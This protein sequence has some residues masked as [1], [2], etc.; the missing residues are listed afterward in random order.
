MGDSRISAEDAPAFWGFALNEDPPPE[1]PTTP[2]GWLTLLDAAADGLDTTVTLGG[3]AKLDG[4]D[5]IRLLDRLRSITHRLGQ[6]DANLVKH[7]YVTGEHGEQ[8]LDGI[9]KVS[10]HRS[11]DRTKWDERG[12]AQAVIDKQMEKRGGEMPSE[13][14]EVISWVLE[15]FGISYCRVTPLRAMGLDPEAFC[16]SSPGKP[17]VTLPPRD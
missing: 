15:V 2:D 4:E 3:M 6:I 10:V 11:R 8:I 7:A 14:W 9:G 5:T 13:P 12:V 17:T 1:L 16:D